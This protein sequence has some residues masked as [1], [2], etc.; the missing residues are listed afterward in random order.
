MAIF[1]AFLLVMSVSLLT[2]VHNDDHNKRF[3]RAMVFCESI[4]MLLSIGY[5]LIEI[6]QLFRYL[7]YSSWIVCIAQV[8]I[9][10][11][12]VTTNTV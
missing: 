5:F 12:T 9:Y 4:T 3:K 1:M 7:F 2:Q 11:Y 10:V 6:D 8:W